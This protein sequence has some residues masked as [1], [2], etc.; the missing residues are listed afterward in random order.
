MFNGTLDRGYNRTV[1]FDLFTPADAKDG[2]PENLGLASTKDITDRILDG[3]R[4][5]DASQSTKGMRLGYMGHLTL[6]A[7]EVV[8]FGNRQTPESMDQTVIDR[9]N[10]HEWTEYVQGTLADTREKD[11]AVRGG[12]R[13]QDS[14]GARSMS[15]GGIQ[16]GF[17]AN[18]ANTLA[19]AGIGAGVA[20]QDSL[21]M[22][23]SN[24]GHTFEI[25]SGVSGFGDDDD[26]E[27]MEEAERSSSGPFTD[28][29][30]VGE[31]SFEDVDMDYR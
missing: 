17:T 19:S 24:V 12:V 3:Q 28:D 31:L 22:Q 30:Q 1:A 25:N 16:A 20:P 9:V 10:R 5:S 8:K 29:E 15:L 7:E 14:M 26:D 11:N 4:A 18:T 27:E 23:E 21:A 2:K 13:P 6:I